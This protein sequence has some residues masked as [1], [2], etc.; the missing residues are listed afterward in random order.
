[1]KYWTIAYPGLSGEPLVETLSEDEIIAEYYP[2]WSSKMIEKYG[3]EQFEKTW[4]ERDCISD[5]VIIHWAEE[6]DE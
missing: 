3:K 6:S 5:W 1:M 4:C 2:Y